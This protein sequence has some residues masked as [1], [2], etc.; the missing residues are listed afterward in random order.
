LT[1]K[2]LTKASGFFERALALDLDNV[3]ALVGMAQADVETAVTFLTED[4]L[5]HLANETVLTKA[6]SLAPNNALAHWL[7]CCIENRTNRAAQAITEC[8]R[9]LTLDR[10]LA[11]AHAEIGFAK[12]ARSR[13]GSRGS[14]EGGRAPLASR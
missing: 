5:A 14:C 11:S 3:D 13:R 6:L 2:Y 4:R 10:N 8:E 9:A 7:M 12:I 1:P